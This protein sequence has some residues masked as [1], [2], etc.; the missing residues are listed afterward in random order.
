MVSQD[1][2]GLWMAYGVR[3]VAKLIETISSDAESV[4]SRRGALTQFNS[5]LSNQESKMQAIHHEP[6]VVVVL[7]TLLGGSDAGTKTLSALSLASLSLVYQG[8]LAVRDAGSVAVLSDQLKGNGDVSVAEA[9]SSALLAISESRDGCTVLMEH[10][11]LV[12]TLV[13]ALGSKLEICRNCL[14]TLAN[15]TR[16]DMGIK[17]ALDSNVVGALRQLAV[18]TQRDSEA[19]LKALQAIWNI[20]NTPEGKVAMVDAAILPILAKH[21]S[22]RAGTPK[23]RRLAAGCLMAITINK[24]GKIDSLCALEPLLDL[25]LST[26]ARD[27]V[28]L[29]TVRSVVLAMKNAAE[30]PQA[31]KEIHRYARARGEDPSKL[32]DMVEGK[33]HDAEDWPI[34]ER[35]VNQWRGEEDQ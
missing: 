16:Q 9:S 15:L 33:M 32:V 19:L 27:V 18:P 4:E 35:Y 14:G 2:P 23:V 11:D 20:G 10:D 6:S 3:G 12:P 1:A 7:T 34:S 24:Q 30:Y 17:Q 13:M 28:D 8:R 31:R 21:C 22:T 29:G 25:L 26:I 5:L